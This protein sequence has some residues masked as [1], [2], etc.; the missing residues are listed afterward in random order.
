MNWKFWQRAKPKKR[1]YEAAKTGRLLFDWVVSGTSGKDQIKQSLRVLRSRSRDL[2]KNDPYAKRFINLVK[3]NVVGPHGI[4]LQSRASDFNRGKEV[5]DQLDR[6][7]IEEAF[8][9]WGQ[10]GIC[11]IDGRLSWVDAQR[12]FISTVARDGEALFQGVTG[13]ASGNRFGYAL[14]FI[15]PE[16]LDHEF[17]DDSKRIANG[18]ELNK[19]G[20]PVA[21]HLFSTGDDGRP[22]RS[23]VVASRLHHEYI[24]EEL[25]KYRGIP[26]MHAVMGGMHHRDKYEEA[27]L[28]GARAAASKMGFLK[29]PDGE[30][31]G[32]GEQADGSLIE[33]FEPGKIQVLPP[34]YE[35]TGFNPDNPSSSF[36]DFS[37]A[38]LRGVG[39]GLGVAYESL[40][41]DLE[42]VNYSSIRQGVL[43]ERDTWQ[44]LQR[45]TIDHFCQPVFDDWLF[46]SLTTGALKLPMSRFGKFRRVQWQPRGWQWVDPAKEVK[47]Q[48]EAIAAKLKSRT[49]CMAEQGRDFTETI[50]KLKEEDDAMKAL[51][52]SLTQETAPQS[53]P[54]TSESGRAPSIRS[55]LKLRQDMKKTGPANLTRHATIERIHEGDDRRIDVAFSSEE[56]VRRHFGSEVLDHSPD[57]VRMEFFSSG[58]APVL[59]DHNPTKQIGVIESASIDED[60]VGRAVVRFG[61]SALASEILT[62]IRDGIRGNTSVGYETYDSPKDDDGVFRFGDWG[63]LELSMVSVPADQTVGVGRTNDDAPKIQIK[64]KEAEMPDEDKKET[65]AAPEPTVVEVIKEVEKNPDPQEVLANRAKENKEILALGAA[66]NRSDLASEHV[67]KGTSLEEFRGALLQV[68]GD[69]P[70]ETPAGDVDMPATEL[71]A[72]SLMRAIRLK[73][74]GSPLDGLEAEIDQEIRKNA[75]RAPHGFYAP[76]NI[77][78]GKRDLTVGSDTAGGHLRPD[79]HR[80]DL[81]VE[82]LRG[83]LAVIAAGATILSGLKGD[84]SIPAQNA[85]TTTFWV[86]ENGAP[87]EGA[88]TYRNIAMSPKT[89]A[90][91]VD[92]SRRL[93]QQSDPQIEQLIRS[94]VTRGLAASLDD[95][96]I[97]GGATNAPSGII[98]TTGIGSIAEGTTD[99]GAASWA[100]VVN[101][102]REVAR[103][104]ADVGRLAFLGS[105]LMVAH[106]MQTLRVASTDS[107]FIMDD[108]GNLLGFKFIST[109]NAP[110]DLT[111]GSGTGLSALI[112]GNFEDL[113]IGFWG[114]GVDILV[115][116]FS[117]STTGAT[118]VTFFQDV[119]VAV[120]HAESFA[121]ALDI[122][123]A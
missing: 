59:L 1:N 8:Q 113:L 82:E 12:M 33:E 28:I 79:D 17:C 87:T 22:V 72:Y 56:P 40:S 47:A 86:A 88:P 100:T 38:I 6:K 103:D 52:L 39:S 10:V 24:V 96:A 51:G 97:E 26:W 117:L 105:P 76:T 19:A 31:L 64:L 123:T 16:L 93:I 48:V 68:I 80:G 83:R 81:F 3:D 115:D 106:L 43:S 70:L 13:K 108:P 55:L 73:A 109:T 110:D 54:G 27:E 62:D 57:S 32:D 4:R 119:D 23:R 45:W 53:E 111:L 74:E 121:A 15:Q 71:E 114:N 5:P 92:L 9:E 102:I 14:K 77:P 46:W 94:E 65:R 34:G 116:P 37:K 84:L 63:P 98:D 42:G 44:C 50:Q 41:G 89:N 36:K 75:E 25:D 69:T 7:F 99:G 120:R 122:E 20:R 101:L 85:A 60:R 90:A 49:A 66:H 58:R 78:W 61:K 107:R 29:T 18:V 21:Y 112:F 67:G 104:N 35:F 30:G 91:Y 11:T 2:V 95:V 118:R